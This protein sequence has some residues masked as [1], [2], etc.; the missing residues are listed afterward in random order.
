MVS[1]DIINNSVEK[2]SLFG[3]VGLIENGYKGHNYKMT[4]DQQKAVV[5]EFVESAITSTK[6]VIKWSIQS[7]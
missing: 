5:V 3:I 2:Y 6:V 1:K 7:P 4:G